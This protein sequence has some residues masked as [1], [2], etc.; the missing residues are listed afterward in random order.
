M[1]RALYLKQPNGRPFATTGA[2]SLGLPLMM[3]IRIYL[4]FMN[5]TPHTFTLYKR[6]SDHKARVSPAMHQS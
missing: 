3:P 1:L 2:H 5:A 4:P 6:H